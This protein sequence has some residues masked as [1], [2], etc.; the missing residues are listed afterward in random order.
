MAVRLEGDICQGEERFLIVIWITKKESTLDW[1]VLTT[2]LQESPFISLLESS[3][4]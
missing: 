3:L 1:S 2:P 4:G